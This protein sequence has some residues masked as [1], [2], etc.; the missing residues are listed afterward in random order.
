[1]STQIPFRLAV[2]RRLT[3]IL[4]EITIANGYQ[5]DLAGAV[6]RGRT[7]FGANDPI[8]MLSLLED[9]R[10]I[11][12]DSAA[13]SGI[14]RGPWDLILQGFAE[15]DAVNPTDPAHILMADSKRRL[16]AE[17][18]QRDERRQPNILGFGY[19]ASAVEDILLGAGVVRPPD[20]DISDKCYFFLPVTLMLVEDHRN[21]FSYAL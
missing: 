5:H 19:K 3:D 16:V 17:R 15:D 13:D 20:G 12:Q 6:F 18:G 7:A 21:P 10:A 9:P 11:A 2:L 8:P 4:S 14:S 1:M